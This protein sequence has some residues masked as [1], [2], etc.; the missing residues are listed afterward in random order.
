MVDAVPRA[1]ASDLF[2]DE[3]KA[4]IAASTE[5]T[6]DAKLSARTF[7]RLRGFFDDEQIVVLILNTSVANLNNRVTDSLEADVEP[8]A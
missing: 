3:E 1:D 6:R 7:E 4:L 5:L 2:T 8:D